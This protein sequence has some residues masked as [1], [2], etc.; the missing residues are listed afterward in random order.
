MTEAIFEG[1][2]FFL[3]YSGSNNAIEVRGSLARHFGSP[4]IDDVT[5]VIADFLGCENESN[6]IGIVGEIAS[7]VQSVLPTNPRLRVAVVTD[8]PWLMQELRARE[9]LDAARF[10][11]GVFDSLEM[12][13]AWLVVTPMRSKHAAMLAH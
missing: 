9:A 2:E 5:D 7:F 3:R 10:P 6:H 8:K 4:R 13:R 1:Q 11:I 12:A